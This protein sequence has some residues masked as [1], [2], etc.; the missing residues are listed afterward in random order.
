MPGSALP[1]WKKRHR[2]CG[3]RGGRLVKLR[4]HRV[5]SD[6]SRLVH[7]LFPSVVLPRRFLEPVDACLVP[8]VDMDDV[9][10]PRR[11]CWLWLS[12]RGANPRNSNKDFIRDFSLRDFNWK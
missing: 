11:P 5:Q 2:R 6:V 7:G 12:K 1:S 4:A 3:R 9:S 10:R 8:L